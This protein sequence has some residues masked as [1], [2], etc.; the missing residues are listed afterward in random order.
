[1]QAALDQTE[2]SVLLGLHGTLCWMPLHEAL[3]H[4]LTPPIMTGVWSHEPEVHGPHKRSSTHDWIVA[5]LCSCC[6]CSTLWSANSLCEHLTAN[7][8]HGRLQS[9]S[10]VYVVAQQE[11]PCSSWHPPASLP[12]S[13]PLAG[14]RGSILYARPP[15]WMAATLQVTNKP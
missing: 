7:K 13:T 4:V 15:H 8:T 1:M 2:T 12:Y 5:P 14:A 10:V 11:H 6:G 3:P 9:M